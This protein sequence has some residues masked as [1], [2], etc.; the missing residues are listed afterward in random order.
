MNWEAL[1]NLLKRKG[2]GEKRCK[3]ICTYIFIVQ[4]FALVDGSPTDF[5]GNSRGLRQGNPLSPMF[6]FL[7][8][9]GGF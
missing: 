8:H 3:K 4:F 9:D 5:F 1:Q 2:F 6:F 7:N